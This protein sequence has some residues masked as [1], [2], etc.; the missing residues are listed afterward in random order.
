MRLLFPLHHPILVLD[1]APVIPLFDYRTTTPLSIFLFFTTSDL[2]ALPPVPPTPRRALA[3]IVTTS[4]RCCRSLLKCT[5]SKHLVNL[6]I[7]NWWTNIWPLVSGQERG[8][9]GRTIYQLF[10]DIYL[11]PLA[12]LHHTFLHADFSNLFV[13][14]SLTFKARTPPTTIESVG[15]W[16]LIGC[17]Y[18]VKF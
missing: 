14:K 6:K 12:C 1:L 5:L 18:S 17:R 11:C 9:Y 8:V 15:I 7:E 13:H 2:F 16:Y 4:N 10:Q 3:T